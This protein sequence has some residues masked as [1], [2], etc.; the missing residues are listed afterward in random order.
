MIDNFHRDYLSTTPYKILKIS[1]V[2]FCQP[3]TRVHVHAFS[4]ILISKIYSKANSI[5]FQKFALS[6]ISLY[7]VIE[8]YII[9]VPDSDLKFAPSKE[10]IRIKGQ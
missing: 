7:T 9:F 5:F 2:P 3:W 4:K 10:F 8:R 6:N 1:Y